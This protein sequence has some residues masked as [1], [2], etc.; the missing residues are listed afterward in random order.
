MMTDFRVDRV[1]EV[2]RRGPRPQVDPV[3]LGCEDK[4]FIFK[5][6]DLKALHKLAGIFGLSLPL[7]DLAQPGKLPITLMRLAAFL[8]TPVGGDAVLGGAGHFR[9]ADL[10][11]KG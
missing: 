11:L 1:S 5:E 8:V 6:V 4:D 10:H 9:R 3:P 7:D 2:K